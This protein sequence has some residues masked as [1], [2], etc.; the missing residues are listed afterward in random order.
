MPKRLKILVVDDDEDIRI[1]VSKWLEGSYKVDTA[2][3]GNDCL[4]KIGKKKYDLILLDVMMPGPTG[5]KLIKKIIDKDSEARI[6]YLT[7]VEMFKPT[8]EQ[9]RKGQVPVLEEH[10]KGYLLKPV[11]KEQVISKIE[12]VLKLEKLLK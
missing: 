11:T 9:Q 4:K 3:D 10:V 1:L 5:G 6:I 7:A 12:E 8:P 2:V